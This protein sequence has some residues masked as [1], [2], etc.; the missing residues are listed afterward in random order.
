M[1]GSYNGAQAE[2]LGTLRT[3]KKG[4]KLS[5][6]NLPSLKDSAPLSFTP[7]N[8]K[9]AIIMFFSVRPDFRKKRSLALLST[10]SDLADTYKTKIDI[11]AVF[12]DKKRTA[13]LKS[14]VAKSSSNI[15]VYHDSKKKIYNTYGVFMMPLV[16]LSDAEGRL[17][18]VIPYNYDVRKIVEGNI[19]LLL[20]EWDKK[21]LAKS[22]ETKKN[23]VKSKEEKEYI[24]R[25][26]YG[27]IMQSKKMHSQ[28]IR[29]F[30][31]A[32]KLMPNLE[33]AHIELGF[34]LLSSKKYDRA[35]AS[36]KE[37]LRI[38]PDSDDAI[39]GIGLTHYG[40][41]EIEAALTELESAF[42]APKP[43]LEV[44]ITLAELYEKKGDNKKANRFNKLAVTRLM[45]LYNQKWK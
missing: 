35:E 45:T 24:R 8:G 12:S 37:A 17:H 32:V 38:N 33:K 36:F 39:A 18:E 44:I 10:L 42:I 41:G 31:N 40:R 3:F 15:N 11:I 28:A 27:R 25:V 4:D 29:E 34:A 16:V 5:P 43:R 6:I 19:K 21:Q 7:G 1:A 2:E 13:T 14:Y 9:P 23:I 22:L 20:G 26:N 30:S